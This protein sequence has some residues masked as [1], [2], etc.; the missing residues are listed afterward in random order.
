MKRSIAPCCLLLFAVALSG[1]YFVKRPPDA[2][3]QA[4][5]DVER[6]AARIKEEIEALAEDTHLAR[7][8]VGED[9]KKLAALVESEKER[10]KK[11]QQAKRATEIRIR[12][13][14]AESR[15]HAQ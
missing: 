1:A 10:L 6:L 12:E 11:L 7:Q 9:R 5:A 14:E 13:L 8:A 15:A 3:G 4:E 2:I